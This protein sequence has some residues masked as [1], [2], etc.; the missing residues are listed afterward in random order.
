MK[1]IRL[2]LLS[3]KE[4][5]AVLFIQYFIIIISNLF[6]DAKDNIYFCSIM[7]CIFDI[8]YIIFNKK[9]LITNFNFK[10]NYLLYIMLGASISTLYNMIIYGL[11]RKSVV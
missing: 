11:D 6:F 1:K 10:Y 4:I 2:F 3:L 9:N 5:F 7:L 8:I